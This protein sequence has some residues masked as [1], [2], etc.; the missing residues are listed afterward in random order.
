MLVKDTIRARA[1]SGFAAVV[2][3]AA[4]M[5]ASAQTPLLTTP[6]PG[7]LPANAPWSRLP[8]ND[9]EFVRSLDLANTLELDQGKYLVNRT[10]DPAVHQFAQHMIDEHS[11]V[12]VRLEALTRGTSVR[13]APRD[14]GRETALGKRLMAILQSE[15]AAQLDTDYMRMQVPLHR[16]ALA[17]LTWESQSGANLNVKALAASLIPNVQQHLQLA[18]NYLAV[19]NLTPYAP[20]DVPLASP[21]ASPRP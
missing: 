1:F 19:H 8:A 14:D 12:A 9:A 7:G 16:R 21:S 4:A 15:T 2:A 3:L 10:R 6:P 17:L 5:A 11:A 20:P 13:P 18:L